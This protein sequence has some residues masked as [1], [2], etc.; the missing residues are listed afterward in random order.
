M[1]QLPAFQMSHT[2]ADLAQDVWQKRRKLLNENRKALYLPYRLSVS[3]H[4]TDIDENFFVHYVVTSDRWF[5]TLSDLSSHRIDNHD[6]LIFES[7]DDTDSSVRGE[8]WRHYAFGDCLQ[9]GLEGRIR[10]KIAAI[11]AEDRVSLWDTLPID[12][13][14]FSKSQHARLRRS[15]FV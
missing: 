13:L 10:Q 11:D 1:L 8:S 3:N 14:R 5:Y 12:N 4:K 2:V 9:P 15:R 6:D 7:D